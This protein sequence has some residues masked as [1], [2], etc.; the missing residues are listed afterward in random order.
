MS[1]FM[2]QAGTLVVCGDAGDALGDSLY[3]THIY[4][5]GTVKSLGADCVA[6][7]LDKFLHSWCATTYGFYFE[8]CKEINQ[9]CE[10]N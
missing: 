7:W 8:N 5:K 10:K 3:E 2:A 1:C 6:Q 4:V 9:M